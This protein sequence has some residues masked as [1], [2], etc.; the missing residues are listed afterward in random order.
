MVSEHQWNIYR[1]ETQTQILIFQVRFCFLLLES[2]V[3]YIEGFLQ[4][5]VR[6]KAP[7]F[8]V[9]DR[10]WNIKSQQEDNICLTSFQV[11][12]TYTNPVRHQDHQV[13]FQLHY[14]FDAICSILL[15]LILL[16]KHY[17]YFL[18]MRSLW[19]CL[20]VCI[21][22]NRDL[23][24]KALLRPWPIPLIFPCYLQTQ[25]I[26]TGNEIPVKK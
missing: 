4:N 5:K 15:F 1:A 18:L 3:P 11:S 10:F 6:R 9:S 17:A 25:K 14:Q 22:I 24:E 20:V 7:N 2:F 21:I 26:T 23:Y 16:N 8:S 19:C 12:E 13:I